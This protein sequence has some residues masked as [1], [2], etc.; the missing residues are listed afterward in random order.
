MA[1]FMDGMLFVVDYQG[2]R[3]VEGKSRQF[4]SYPVLQGVA[5]CFLAVPLEP[6]IY[7]VHH[8]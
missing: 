3:V 5:L 1:A 4:E 2:E 6:Y 8:K 7:S